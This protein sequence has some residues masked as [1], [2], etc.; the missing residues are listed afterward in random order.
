MKLHIPAMSSMKQNAQLVYGWLMN[1]VKKGV[2]LIKDLGFFYCFL[3]STYLAILIRRQHRSEHKIQT[4][5]M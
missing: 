4:L 3:P 2:D 1:H 5:F